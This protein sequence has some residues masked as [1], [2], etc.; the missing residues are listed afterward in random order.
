MKS[1]L[2]STFCFLSLSI[3]AQNNPFAGTW[4]GK[5]KVGVSLRLVFNFST[6]PDGSMLCTWKSP[7]Q[8]EQTFPTDTC[9]VVADSI[10]TSAQS[11]GIAFKGELKNDSTIEGSFT[12]GISI[13][14]TLIKQDFIAT[15]KRPQTPVK[16]YPYHSEDYIFYN[17]DSSLHF[18][19]TLTY[20]KVPDNVNYV[21]IPT[22]P[23]VLLIS[24]SGPQDRDETIFGH[25]P[26]AVLADELS[27]NGFA[28][29][30]YDDRGVGKSSGNFGTATSED[31]MKDAE[32]A[33]H[34]LYS[35]PH[36]DTNRL[37]IIGHSE[38]GMIAPMLAADRKDIKYMVLLAGPGIPITDLMYEQIYAIGKL[39]AKP[40]VAK[41]GADLFLMMAKEINKNRDSAST[42]NNIRKKL[43][44]WIKKT[45][46]E[47]VKELQLD[48]EENKE[49]Y[50]QTQYEGLSTAWF[51]YF[52]NYKPAKA[53]KKTTAKVLA[54]NGSKDIQVFA[55][56]NLK[57]IEKA[58]RKSKSK[59]YSIQ[60]LEGLNHLFQTCHS[61]TI[62]EYNELEE[63][64]A[65]QALHLIT[66]WLLNNNRN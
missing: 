24:G 37:G 39:G 41:A 38:G 8:S 16:P 13:P 43:N 40:H 61:C 35:L 59:Q 21:K 36:V 66:Q 23:T 22:Y 52:L 26:F 18:G 5:I 58:L 46:P 54:I 45:N 4:Q 42:V 29:L 25:K 15:A 64:M 44:K 28:V 63:T 11:F 20:P 48:S 7:D 31:F 2:L 56:S 32:A 50:I 65:P 34:F 12:Q 17:A 14:L 55:D 57:G 53:L 47:W 1:I 30:R 49:N 10:F 27:K 6:Q 9:F 62:A 33:L 60:K 3:S 19:A 51:K